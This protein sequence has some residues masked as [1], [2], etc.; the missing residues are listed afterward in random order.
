M[1]YMRKLVF[2]D[3][4]GD[5]VKLALKYIKHTLQAPKAA[6]KVKIEI[7]K[8]YKKIKNRPFIYPIVS[9]DYLASM[10]FRFIKIK[11][12]MLFYTVEE[13]EI[14]IVRFLYGRRDWVSILKNTS[15]IEN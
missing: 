10:G 2:A 8:A 4:F 15:I 11:N 9:N 3:T 7:K 1:K 12:F 6:D 5:D 13:K 14:H